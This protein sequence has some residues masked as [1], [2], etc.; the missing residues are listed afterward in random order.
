[1]SLSRI[2]EKSSPL[3]E[4]LA[5]LLRE[6]RWILLVAVAAYLMLILSGYDRNDPAWST[7]ARAGLTLNPGGVLGAWLSDILL[8][9]FGM[10]AWWWVAFLLQRVWSGYHQLAINSVFDRRAWW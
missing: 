1:M 6:S 4:R 9:L 2:P 7:S 8:Y 10:S 3:P 5:T